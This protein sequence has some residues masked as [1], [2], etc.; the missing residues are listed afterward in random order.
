MW[1]SAQAPA[2]LGF[3]DERQ[4]QSGVQDVLVLGDLNR[5]SEDDPTDAFRAAG[6]TD[7][8]AEHMPEQ[9]RLGRSDSGSIEVSV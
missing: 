2:L 1:W 3:I 9:R 6:L 8:L 4:A 5:N 7:R